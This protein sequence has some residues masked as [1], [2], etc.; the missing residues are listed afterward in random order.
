MSTSLDNSAPSE[1]A[2]Q[3]TEHLVRLRRRA[4][5]VTAVAGV[6]WCLV[7]ATVLFTAFVAAL[8][9]WGGDT[10]RVVGWLVVCLAI[11]LSFG[12]AVVG[13]LQHLASLEAIARRVGRAAPEIASDILSA[14]QFS[15][16]RPDPAFSRALIARHLLRARGSL[17][18]L[19]AEAVFPG[20]VLLAPIGA[21]CAAAL[22][23][24]A[25]CLAMPGV[26]E[27]GARSLLSDPHAPELALV[28][29]TERA[30]VVRDLTVT[31]Y[32][33]DYLERAP[34]RFGASTGGLSAPLGTT[35][36]LDAQSR[37]P[38]ADRGTVTLPGNEV[39]PVQVLPDG[40]VSTRFSITAPGSFWI[41]LG[42]E[43]SLFSGP[44]R[45][46][47][48]EPD[49]PPSIELIRPTGT[50]EINENGEE[51]LEFEAVDD[52]G[53]DRIDLVLRTGPG[54]EVRK[55]VARTAKHVSRFKGRY[56]FSPETLRLEGGPRV[57][58][59]LEAFDN[60]TIR[61]P[62]P[63]RSKTLIVQLMTRLSRHEAMLVEQGHALDALVD[64]LAARLE[65]APAAE[66]KRD[67][68][69]A[70]RFDVVRA[71]TEDF[72]G[73]GARLIH[74]M[75][76]DQ[77]SSRVVVDAFM[78][79]REDLSNQLLHESRFYAGTLGPFRQR[80][81]ADRV[82]IRLIEDAVLRIDD[83]MLDQQ[84]TRLVADGGLLERSR[85]EIARLLESYGGSRSE[86]VRRALLEAI[87]RLELLARRLTAG[88]RDVRGEVA[89]A[90]LNAPRTAMIDLDAELKRLRELL[91]A[92]DISEASQL[93]ADLEQKLA[94]LMTALESGR[95]SYRTDRFGEGEKFLGDLL[96]R[97][98][99]VE[100]EQLQLR[101]ETTAVQRWYQE[102]LMDL[103][104][105]RIDPL[106]KRQLGEVAKIEEELADLGNPAAPEKRELLVRARVSARELGLALGQGDLDEARQLGEE[107]V[108][109][110]SGLDETEK[111][112]LSAG[113]EKIARAASRLVEELT[114]AYPKPA[115]VFGDR[116]RGE[117]RE[118]AAA[119]RHLMARTKSLKAWIKD[120]GDNPRFLIH[121]AGTSL[122]EA[123]VHMEQGVA[124]LEGKRVR[125]ALEAQTGALEILARLRE[126]LKRGGDLVPLE[127]QPVA[128]KAEVDIPEP[129][130]YQVPAEFRK[131]ILDAMRDEAPSDYREAIRKYY[132]TLVR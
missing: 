126:D 62:K 58:V 120:Q 34:R 111:G 15:S 16:A 71:Q 114:E 95:L 18:A 117:M 77:F 69:S 31:L 37:I 36:V 76:Q 12:L 67:P 33:P 97:L 82:T 129:E 9:W 4:R 130:D 30:P 43:S 90:Y 105:G 42:T 92:D 5:L 7:A 80:Q 21:A 70:E 128:F 99:A 13:P 108:E 64:L 61:G 103:M 94:R 57:E 122:D 86:A 121:Q 102:R 40:R 1:P 39:A 6:S 109:A 85:A 11:V 44:D 35:V 22:L 24:T 84:L 123:A 53:I 29:K 131:D 10:I 74:Q 49:Y 60:D 113:L 45:P 98:L 118:Q 66:P 72:L 110:A 124:H 38:G 23:S 87:D 65:A 14:C 52:N 46:I 100:S 26:V 8:G 73:R 3:I 89:D 32:Y 88:L 17:A 51:N 106:V 55:T 107:L 48:I 112:E 81:S 47:E 63:G 127:P 41:A 91:A 27:T 28:R 75:N 119:Q 115:Q 68:M 20:R 125:D 25:V 93:A 50:V 116:E 19:P 104:R 2:R 78:Q 54:R 101:R 132:E 59:E 56:R 83:L 96:D 79:M